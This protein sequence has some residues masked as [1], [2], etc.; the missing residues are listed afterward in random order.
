MSTKKLLGQYYTCGNPFTFEAFHN[1]IKL[2][3][4][5][6]LKCVAEPFAGANNIVKLVSEA[7][8]NFNWLCYDIDPSQSNSA[9]QFQ[10]TKQDTI[11]NFPKQAPTV[12]T[13]PPYL[14]K[15]SAS[16][17]KLEYKYNEWDDL[18]KKCLDVILTNC[19]YA[20]A[21]IPES[22]IT[23]GIFHNRL[24][25]TISIVTKMFEDTDCPVCLALF[26]PTSQKIYINLSDNDFL[27]FRNDIFIGN[28]NQLISKLSAD[29]DIRW[30]FNDVST[31]TIGIHC[32]DNQLTD[33]IRFC[34]I[35]EIDLNKVKVSTRNNTIVSGL[36]KNI[37]EKTFIDECNKILTQYRKDT[38]DVFLTAFKGLRKDNKYRRRLDFNVASTIMNKAVENINGKKITELW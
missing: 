3:P 1:W 5:C 27:L 21:I 33:S 30:K 34:D 19:D 25:A 13:N 15:N 38:E 6:Y 26:I 37:E 2:I 8:Y 11:E 32:V 14:A 22:F 31:A 28:Y 18:Y 35:S 17:M 24:Y 16:K 12:I 36:P 29:N 10:I 20:A 23:A 7:G 9:P 4:G